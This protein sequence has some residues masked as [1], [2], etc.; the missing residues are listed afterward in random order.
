MDDLN[1]TTDESESP[2]PVSPKIILHLCATEGS[3]SKPYQ[4]A[5]YDVR[6]IGE[7]IGVENYSPPPEC[8]RNNRQPPLHDVLHSEDKRKNSTR[9]EG[10]YAPR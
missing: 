2:S 7:E 4:E 3:D 1:L 9:F 5:G 6:I 10:R 8:L